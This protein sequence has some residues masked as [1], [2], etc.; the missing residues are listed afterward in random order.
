MPNKLRSYDAVTIN[1]NQQ[2]KKALDALVD[3]RNELIELVDSGGLD[4]KHHRQCLETL[5]FM[6]QIIDNERTKLDT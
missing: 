4:E 3:K 1:E 6:N 5:V 2:R